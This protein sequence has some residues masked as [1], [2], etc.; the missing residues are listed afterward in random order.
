MGDAAGGADRLH[1]EALLEL[2]QPV[3]EAFPTAENY[4]HDRYVHVVDQVEGEKLADHRWSSADADIEATGS[5]PGHPQGLG[6]AGVDEVERRPAFHLNRW[7]GV[8]GEDEH[9]GM[10]GWLFAPP[11]LPLL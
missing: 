10:K 6:R 4:G 7:P 3:P 2:L 11:A 9:R 8:M 5:F 1:I